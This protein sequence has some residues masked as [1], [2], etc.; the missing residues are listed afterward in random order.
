MNL[1]KAGGTAKYANHA[2]ADWIGIDDRFPHPVDAFS[3]STLFLSRIWGIPR[4]ELPS[5]GLMKSR[6]NSRKIVQR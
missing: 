2:K 3:H 1:E 6:L 5:S 4:F